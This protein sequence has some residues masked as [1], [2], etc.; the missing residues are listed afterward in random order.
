MNS[1]FE[2]VGYTVDRGALARDFA[3]VRW[4][5]FESWARAFDWKSLLGG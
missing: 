3:D 1:W 4:T 2:R 5:S